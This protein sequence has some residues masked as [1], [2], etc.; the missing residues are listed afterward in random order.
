VGG[1]VELLDI[2]HAVEA[3][4]RGLKDVASANPL[5]PPRGSGLVL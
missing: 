2:V 5:E 3:A 1:V 4:L